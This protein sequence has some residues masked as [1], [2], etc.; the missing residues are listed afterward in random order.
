M[1]L[2]LFYGDSFSLVMTKGR[3]S[4]SEKEKYSGVL[5]K[6]QSTSL[7][8]NVLDWSFYSFSLCILLI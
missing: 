7:L 1:Q 4:Y 3:L 6:N 2:Y 5:I 8:N